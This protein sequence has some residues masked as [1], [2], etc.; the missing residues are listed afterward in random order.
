MELIN[1]AKNLE[2]R[3]RAFLISDMGHAS[4]LGAPWE[5]NC[6][7]TCNHFLR[8][9]MQRWGPPSR[10]PV[11][12]CVE[13]LGHTKVDYKEAFTSHRFILANEVRKG[14]LQRQGG[15]GHTRAL[16]P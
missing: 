14:L 9:D 16:H 12:G 15:W 6:Y 4:I 8:F 13:D 7:M 5:M 1:M 10:A 2:T 3:H 11:I